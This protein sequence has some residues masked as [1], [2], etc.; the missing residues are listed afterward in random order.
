MESQ[1]V[2]YKQSWKD[3]YLKWVCGFANAQGGTLYI[4]IDDNG[5]VCDLK[6]AKKL[7]KDIPNKIVNYLGVVNDVDLL[8]KD[9]KDYIRITVIPSN[10]PIT[11]HGKLYYRSGSTLQELSGTAA[12]NF[13]LRKMGTTWDSQIVEHSSLNDI[14][15][16]AVEYFLRKG[17][18]NGR[19]TT[20]AKNDSLQKILANL[21]LVDNDGRLTMAALMLFGKDPQQFCLNARFKIGRFGRNGGE[22][23]TQDLIEGNLIQMADKV[24]SILSDK[25][26][27]RPIHYEGLQ[28]IEPLEIPE[29]GLRELIYNAII[30]KSYDGPDIQMKVFD[31]R[32]TLWNYGMLPDGITVTNMFSEHSSMPRNRLIANTFY[33]AGF[34]EAWG[35]GFETVAE[36]FRKEELEVPTFKEEFGGLTVTIKR[37]IFTE[38]QR[39]GRIDDKTGRIVKDDNSKNVAQSEGKER[40]L[41]LPSQ[42]NVTEGKENGS[43][44]VVSGVVSLSQVHLTERQKRVCEIIENNPFVSS[45][46]MSVVLSVDSRTVQRD[47]ATLQ[48]NGVLI[49]EGNTS[50]GRWVLTN[51][52]KDIFVKPK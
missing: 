4:G 27:I 48:K 21:R 42:S 15:T 30:H 50:A 22:L 28:R 7:M 20:E 1:T 5:N 25:F 39:G 13:L 41:S 26:L 11:Y 6:D 33:L 49:R 36:S 12:Q 38:I 31:D 19:L 32:I 17:V 51:R 10:T 52:W 46:Q 14:D 40:L 18:D 47:L 29:L 37:E 44:N 2:E 9:G 24:M 16:T 43:N 8:N 23:F 45:K 3:D 34:I 35:R